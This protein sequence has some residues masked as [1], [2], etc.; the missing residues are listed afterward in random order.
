[1]AMVVAVKMLLGR[2]DEGM[3]YARVVEIAPQLHQ[4]CVL[5]AAK[6]LKACVVKVLG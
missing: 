2:K 6:F 1:M 4:L 5:P 3:E